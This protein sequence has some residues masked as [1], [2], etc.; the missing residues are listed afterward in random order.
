MKTIPTKHGFPISAPL[1][2]VTPFLLSVSV[3]LTASHIHMGGIIQYLPFICDW[4][5]LLNCPQG[6]KTLSVLICA[7]LGGWGLLTWQLRQHCSAPAC[8]TWSA[9]CDTAHGQL[10]GRVAVGW[11]GQGAALFTLTVFMDCGFRKNEARITCTYTWKQLSTWTSGLQSVFRYLVL[12]LST[13]SFPSL[14]SII[15]S[16]VCVGIAGFKIWEKWDEI[17]RI[18]LRLGSRS[19]SGQKTL[20]S[21]FLDLQVHCGA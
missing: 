2:L 7:L 10:S 5:I 9:A 15:S 17:E 6:S 3:T 18:G 19:G 20:V 16:V 14:T 4:L 11:D 12:M 1:G 21:F 8:D 13:L